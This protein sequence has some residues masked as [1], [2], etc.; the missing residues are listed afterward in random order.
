MEQANDSLRGAMSPE[1]AQQ[2][3]ALLNVSNAGVGQWLVIATCLV[4]FM[5]AGFLLLESGSVR[6]KNTINVSLKN[7]VDL[8]VCGCSFLL[9]GAAIMFGDSSSSFFGLGGFDMSDPATQLKLL[10]QFAFCATAATIISGA[11]AERMSFNGY[12][13]L[14]AIM[15]LLIYPIFGRLVWGGALIPGNAAML[16]D[17]GFLDYAGSTV[18]H[19]IGG[20]ASLAAVIM[21]GAR[22][23]RFN[24]NGTVNP[25]PGHSSVLALGGLMILLIGW[26][27]F[28]TGAAEPGSAMFAQIAINTVIS[29]SFGGGAAI[30]YDMFRNAGRLRVRATITGI[31][32]GLIGITAGCAYVSTNGAMVIGA[33]CGLFATYMSDVLLHRFKIDDPVDAVACHGFAGLAGTI[34]V[35]LL[36]EPQYLVGGSRLQQLGVQAFG[37]GIAFVWAFGVTALAIFMMQRLNYSVRVSAEAEDIGLNIAEHGDGFDVEG[38]KRMVSAVSEERRIAERRQADAAAKAQNEKAQLLSEHTDETTQPAH[39]ARLSAS[40]ADVNDGLGGEMIDENSSYDRSTE[41]GLVGQVISK[42]RAIER[43]HYENVARLED[44]EKV[45]NDWLFETDATMRI[46]RISAKF[47]KVFGTRAESIIGRDYFS[48]IT[49]YDYSVASHRAE[50]ALYAAFNDVIFKV[51]GVDRIERYFSLSGT[52]K[53]TDAGKFDGYRGRALDVTEKLKTDAELRYLALH[54]QLT[55]LKNR[56]A[57]GNFV[58]AHIE[59]GERLLVGSIDLDGFKGVNDTHGHHSGDLLLKLIAERLTAILGYD[60]TIARFGGDEFVFA[61]PL[62]PADTEASVTKLCNDVVTA[63]CTPANLDN[64]EIFVGGSLGLCLFPDHQNSLAT[65]LRGS[66]MALYDAKKAGRGQWVMFRKELEERAQRQ[67]RLEAEMPKALADGE[68][69]LEYQPQVAAETGRIKGFEA[70]IR[71]QHPEFDLIPPNQ[72]IEI[73]EGN[74]FIAELGAYVLNEACATAAA[75]PILLGEELQISVNVSP[76]QFYKQDIVAMVTKALQDTGLDP[77]RLELEITESALIKEP[78]SAVRVLNA[79]RALGVRVAV[80]DFGTGYSSLA[81]LQQFPLDRLKVDRAFVRNIAHGG[82]DR[83]ITE[84]IIQLGKSLGLNVI[85]EGVETCDQ[86]QTLNDIQVDEIQGYL[87]SRPLSRSQTLAQIIRAADNDGRLF[88]STMKQR[89]TEQNDRARAAARQ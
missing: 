61:L 71:W 25:M 36:A 9:V 82:N 31:L 30:L 83:R 78:E 4:L 77:A 29:M 52:A 76:V 11:V 13:A 2:L 67:K 5:Q 26:L 39:F 65:L 47:Y 55:G 80:D 88:S 10:F 38:L 69:L 85:A 81:F 59:T 33:L 32:G 56:A 22:R 43:E 24:A 86:Y 27:G 6:S 75:W 14:T 37:S 62:K 54:D 15:A 84:A 68:F 42:A 73:A 40:E 7:V 48:L 57:F 21:I 79:V 1:A 72:F 49:E 45:G 66:D 16:A 70:L 87:F 53:F 18:V 51:M 41:I 35:A 28:N 64:V 74:G 20:W 3:G 58:N 8:I 89:E 17:I 44:I 60:A 34:L 63:L 12:I 46:S 19:A 50:I 23:G